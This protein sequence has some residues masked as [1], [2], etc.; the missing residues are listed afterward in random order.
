[1]KTMERHQPHRASH[2]QVELPGRSR[3]R[4]LQDGHRSHAEPVLHPRSVRVHRQR[5]VHQP[6]VLRHAQPRDDLRRVHLRKPSGLRGCS[7]VLQPLQHVPH[8]GAATSSTSTTRCW[9]SA[10]PQRTEPDAIDAIAKNIFED[11]TSPVETILAFNIP[12]NRA[13]MHLDTV[14]TQIDVDKFTIHPGIIKSLTSSRSPP[15]RRYQGRRDERQARGHPREV[16]R[17]PRG[18]HSCGSGDRR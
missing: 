11:E 6:H 3:Q 2:R 8:R 13:M 1:M 16:R 5:R 9:P 18:A 14:F 12:N 15:G 4:V 10:F 7:R 17:Q